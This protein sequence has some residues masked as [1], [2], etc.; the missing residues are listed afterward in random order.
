MSDE[1]WD[2]AKSM[3][4]CLS[5]LTAL[6]A[7]THTARVLMECRLAGVREQIRAVGELG[8]GCDDDGIDCVGR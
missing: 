3:M 5:D 8:K 4:R 2:G 6:L 7:V 1:M